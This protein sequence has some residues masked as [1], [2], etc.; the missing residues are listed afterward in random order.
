MFKSFALGM[1]DD[2]MFRSQMTWNDSISPFSD[3]PV[4]Q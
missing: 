1:N 3:I 2:K 4:Q